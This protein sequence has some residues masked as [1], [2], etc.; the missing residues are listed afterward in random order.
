LLDNPQ[1]VTVPTNRI[2]KR[3]LFALEPM[4]KKARRTDPVRGA[5]V[6]NAAEAKD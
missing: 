6:E 4:R 3:V 2:G 1:N 5:E